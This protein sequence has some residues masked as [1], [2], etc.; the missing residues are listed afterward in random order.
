MVISEKSWNQDHIHFLFLK[1]TQNK[2]GNIEDELKKI[3]IITHE[4]K[5]E[6][7]RIIRRIMPDFLYKFYKKIK[8]SILKR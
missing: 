1:R 8:F 3:E 7:K 5:K 6:D 2:Q 4:K